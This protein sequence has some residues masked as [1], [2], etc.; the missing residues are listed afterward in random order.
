ME[1]SQKNC[2]GEYFSYIKSKINKVKFNRSL[3]RVQMC[4]SFLVEI[5]SLKYLK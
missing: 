3:V 2:F 5:I 1:I 4:K